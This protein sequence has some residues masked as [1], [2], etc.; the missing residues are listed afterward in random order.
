MEDQGRRNF[1]KL[2]GVLAASTVTFPSKFLTTTPEHTS[3]KKI[4][5]QKL[6]KGDTI[7]I[8]GLAGAVWDENYI[9]QFKSTL[10]QLGFK[11]KI[12]E[13]V[14]KKF[15]YLSGTDE[16]RA[17]ELNAFFQDPTVKAIFCIK[18]GWGSARIIDLIDYELIKKNP[19]VFMGFS[20]ITSLL[21][22]IY[23]Q[24][25][26][27]TFHGPVGYST[28]NTFSIEALKNVLFTD[29]P[30]PFPSAPPQ[31]QAFQTLKSGT[32]K[33]EMVGGNLSV[34]CSL[35]GSVY[36]SQ[37][38]H[39]ILFLEETH[40]EPYRVDRMLTT[41]RLAGIFDKIS[42]IV[43]GQFTHCEPENPL[44]SFTLLEV[45][46]QHVECLNVPVFMGAP[47]GHVADKWT[48]PVGILCEMNA[49]VGTLKPLES[50]VS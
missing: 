29:V 41:L 21:N 14:R 25:G 31:N 20:D 46:K 1:I 18:G 11:I 42:G 3:V 9:N 23:S 5:P 50:A 6:T 48:I 2:S 19:K 43:L 45:L 32:A 28:W 49:D 34:I 16:D 36:L 26:L 30:T 22:S 47:I 24:T 40:E 12:G 44:T 10:L 4:K 8:A 39:K 33:G 7:A 38:D 13:N 15:G 27:V 17:N 37:W 35:M